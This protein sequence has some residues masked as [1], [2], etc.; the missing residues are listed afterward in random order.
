M[1]LATKY[2]RFS[3]YN[4]K[5]VGGFKGVRYFEN[6]PLQKFLIVIC[7][8]YKP[9]PSEPNVPNMRK[10]AETGACNRKIWQRVK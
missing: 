4:S 2:H 3:D 10:L 6:R 5:Y 1:D 9:L 7:P 8:L